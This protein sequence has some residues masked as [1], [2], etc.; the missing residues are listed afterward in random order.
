MTLSY[1][2]LELEVIRWAE[3]RRIIPNATPQSQLNKCLEEL[4]ELFKA[5]NQKNDAEIRDGCGDVLVTLI[6]YC[7]L[8]DIYLVACLQLAYNE[9][10]DRKGTLKPDGTFV[11]E[12]TTDFLKG[13]Q[14]CDN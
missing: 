2:D 5:E 8:K 12:P 10:K 11:K 6:L 9:I 7:A 13:K 4:A 14:L 3:Q 1:R